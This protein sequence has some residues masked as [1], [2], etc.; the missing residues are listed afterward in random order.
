MPSLRRAGYGMAGINSD[1]S[2]QNRDV[3]FALERSLEPPHPEPLR[4]WTASLSL[5]GYGFR[6]IRSFQQFTQRLSAS[7]DALLLSPSP[8]PREWI[9]VGGGWYGQR[10]RR[11]GG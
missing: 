10:H 2:D 1:L 5:A 9:W 8:D 3:G 6:R 4:W 11:V 7:V